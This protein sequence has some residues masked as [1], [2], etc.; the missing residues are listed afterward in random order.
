MTPEEALQRIRMEFLRA[1]SIHPVLHSKHE[2][3]AVIEEEFLELREDIFEKYHA[4]TD[5]REEATQTA[6]MCMRLMVDLL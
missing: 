6:A 4:D 5:I 2:A 3:L 1:S